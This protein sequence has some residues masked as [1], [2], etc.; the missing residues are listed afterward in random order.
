MKCHGYVWK[1]KSDTWYTTVNERFVANTWQFGSIH[2]A[3][4]LI[5]YDL[6]I[7]GK[8]NS[9]PLSKPTVGI[10]LHPGKTRDEAMKICLDFIEEY[11]SSGP[12]SVENTI[13]F[14]EQNYSDLY[15]NRKAI[16]DHLFF[17]IGNGYD[18]L[19]GCLVNTSPHDHLERPAR[20][21]ENK[22]LYEAVDEVKVLLKSADKDYISFD[23]EHRMHWEADIH[24]F[25][26]VSK[27]FSNICQ[28]PDDVKPDWLELAYEAALLLRDKSGVPNLKSKRYNHTE[29]DYKRQQENRE[30]GAEIVAQ[31]ERRFPHVKKSQQVPS[32]ETQ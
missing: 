3:K 18:W 21:E 20:R 17:V 16:I 4:V 27:D 12:I 26:P 1:N 13:K 25:Y 9:S 2:Q 14:C 7:D 8:P 30:I 6:K 23:E 11:K 29:D 22:D 19:D 24:R 10:C 32:Q 28:V 5:D 31:L 15:P